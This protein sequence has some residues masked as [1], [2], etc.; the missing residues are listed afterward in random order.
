MRSTGV[1]KL[2]SER[3]LQDYSNVV[4]ASSGLQADVD[5]QLIEE[6]RLANLSEYQKYIALVFDKVKVKEDLAYNKHSGE[7]MDFVDS[8]I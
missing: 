7:M 8:I 5:M 6:A 4:T 3:T 1:L 2:P